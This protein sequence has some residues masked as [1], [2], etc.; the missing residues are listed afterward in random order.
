MKYNKA[1]L[2]KGGM[3]DAIMKYMAGGKYMK[4]GGTGFG[5]LSVKAGIDKNPEVTYADK[6]AGAT[7][8][9]GGRL[10][11]VGGAV[12]KYSNGT[13]GLNGVENG[14]DNGDKSQ[15]QPFVL[16]NKTAKDPEFQR[17]LESTGQRVYKEATPRG[18]YKPLEP[19]QKMSF[20]DFTDMLRSDEYRGEAIAVNPELFDMEAV[21]NTPGQFG[22]IAP[23]YEQVYGSTGR[24]YAEFPTYKDIAE[25]EMGRYEHNREV[26]RK[27]NEWKQSQQTPRRPK[28]FI[29]IRQEVPGQPGV[30][31]TIRVPQ[32]D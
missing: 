5:N 11:R 16:N 28:G 7:M 13:A 3:Y 25:G 12:P 17:Y 26:E 18:K 10:Y 15:T 22:S 4:E 21:Q 29:S 8:D 1:K 30:Y 23:K 24:K 2:N 32:Y 9:E 20:A 6:I 19:G 31:E 27:Y 14:D